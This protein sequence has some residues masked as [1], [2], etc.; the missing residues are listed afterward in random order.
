MRAVAFTLALLEAS[1]NHCNK[2]ACLFD[3]EPDRNN[4]HGVASRAATIERTV[5]EVF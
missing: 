2:G 1:I 4:D 5:S 3:R